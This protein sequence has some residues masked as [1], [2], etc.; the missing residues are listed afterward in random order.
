M[1][2]FFKTYYAPNNAVLVVAGDFD[3]A[4]VMA[5]SEKY[6]GGIP[7]ARRCRRGP[8]SPSRGRSEEKRAKTEDD[9]LATRRRWRSAITCPRAT[10][11][12]STRWG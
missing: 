5:G 12:S 4:Q 7:S 9:K 6:F 10:R 3:P 1:Q 11:P 2:Q 8:T